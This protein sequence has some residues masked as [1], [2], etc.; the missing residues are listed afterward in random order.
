VQLPLLRVLQHYGLKPDKHGPVKLQRGVTGAWN[1]PGEA[2]LAR[3]L[4]NRAEE[5]ALP[6]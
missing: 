3:H 6:A 1:E 5:T 4:P 2:G